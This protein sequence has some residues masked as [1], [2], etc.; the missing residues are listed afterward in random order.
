MAFDRRDFLRIAGLTGL[1]VVTPFGALRATEPSKRK[2]LFVHAGGGW[3]P[4]SL[5]DP[6]GRDN[7]MD[8]DGVN[9]YFKGDI[10]T[11]GN[12]KYA[13]F[14][15]NQ[16][17]FDRH[18][19]RTLVINGV[20]TQTNNHSAGARHTW[21]GKLGEG[22]PALAALIASVQAKQKPMAFISN[23]GYDTT[24]GLI[25]PTRTGNI[26][27]VNRL[28]HP[29]I[30]DVNDENSEQFHAP[31]TQT[32]LLEA[33]A[34]R[35]SHL[36]RTFALPKAKA[37]ISQLYTAR[38]GQNEVK[39]LSEFLPEEFHNGRIQQQA[40]VAIAA[41][42]ADIAQTANLSIGGFDTHA[43]HD[44]AQGSALTKLMK[45]VSF[46]WDE[47][48]RQGIADDLVVMV[49]SDFGRTPGYNSGN[50]KDHWA[51]TSVLLMGSGI[52]GNKVI[53]ETDERHRPKRIDPSTLAVSESGVRI[54]PKHIHRALRTLAGVESS[55]VA[56]KLFPLIG[57]ENMPLLG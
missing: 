47:A 5:C 12:I 21:S 13:P 44:D 31:S 32:R 8:E 9:H 39:R 41:F 6:K 19:R 54:E 51:V 23:G 10:G 17:F 28:A 14:A 42:R 24:S 26:G 2:W 15:W 43:N 35:R 4:T 37:T 29:F 40:Q 48:E 22:Y 49:S 7:E 36:E 53:G 30:I 1:A 57:V 33:M 18:Y 3:D 56:Q 34:K 46:I 45:G 16:E 50:G 20:D 25:A 27:A 52:P 11:A 55:E 38:A